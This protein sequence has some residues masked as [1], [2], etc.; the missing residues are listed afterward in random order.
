MNLKSTAKVFIQYPI[1]R[2]EFKLGDSVEIHF[3]KDD[4][5]DLDLGASGIVLK[6]PYK[7]F[8]EDENYLYLGVVSNK[9]YW[10]V[11][12]DRRHNAKLILYEKLR[13]SETKFFYTNFL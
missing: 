13:K 8:Y 6:S 2:E 10:A 1:L 3:E 4:F 7:D 12:E 11:I 9:P 5:E